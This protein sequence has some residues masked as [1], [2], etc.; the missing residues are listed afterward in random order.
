[1]GPDPTPH[2]HRA[3]LLESADI[4]GWIKGHR[5]PGTGLLQSDALD[6]LGPN[7]TRAALALPQAPISPPVA[8]FYF[9]AS[10]FSSKNARAYDAP[11]RIRERP[12]N[13]SPFDFRESWGRPLVTSMEQNRP[14]TATEGSRSAPGSAMRAFARV[15]E[16][17]RTLRVSEPTGRLGRGPEGPRV[18][19]GTLLGAREPLDR[20][21]DLWAESEFPP[22]LVPIRRRDVPVPCMGCGVPA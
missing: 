5:S 10:R 9:A 6:L 12:P 18:A 19:S 15:L 16:P 3:T 13:A 11:P 2:A 8:R 14:S 20:G 17:S 4:P 1:M 21:H 22:Q 7:A